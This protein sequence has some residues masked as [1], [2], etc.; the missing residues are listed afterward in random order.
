MRAHAGM[1]SM[2]EGDEGEEGE[3]GAEED[4]EEDHLTAEE[5]SLLE[6]VQERL[7]GASTEEEVDEALAGLPPHIVSGKV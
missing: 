6:S 3:G 2:A 5:E 4:G 7:D 1:A